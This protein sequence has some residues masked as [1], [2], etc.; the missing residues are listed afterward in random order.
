MKTMMETWAEVNE[1]HAN[2][3]FQLKERWAAES[4][5][6]DI[7]EYLKVIQ[8]KIPTATNITKR[9]FGVTIPCSDGNLKVSVVVDGRYIKLSGKVVA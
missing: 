2:M 1:K 5:Y 7:K 3:F 6:E 9:P 4:E 8:K